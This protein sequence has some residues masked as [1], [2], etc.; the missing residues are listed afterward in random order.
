MEEQV[1]YYGLLL[2]GDTREH[3]GG[4]ARRRVLPDGQIVEETFRKDLRWHK[5]DVVWE[6]QRGE[7]TEQLIEITQAEAERVMERFRE[8]FG[9]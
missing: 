9:R 7:T 1:T 2:S 8:T 6:W 3:P 4:L 5:D